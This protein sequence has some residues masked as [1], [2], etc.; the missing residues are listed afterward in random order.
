MRLRRTAL[1]ATL[2]AALVV[3]LAAV[4]PAQAEDDLKKRKQRVEAAIEQLAGDIDE[5]SR[6]YALALARQRA[7]EA[8]LP[9]ARAAVAQAKGQLAAA[10]ARE[11]ALGQ[12]LAVAVAQVAKAEAELDEVQVDIEG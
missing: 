4:V 3:P 8:K 6:E 5:V 11:S 9:P 2:L 12:R 10:K 7:V 1:A